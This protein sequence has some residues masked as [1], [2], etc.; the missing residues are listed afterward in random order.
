MRRKKQGLEPTGQVK[1]KAVADGFDN[2][3]DWLVYQETKEP[4]ATIAARKV[5]AAWA[6]QTA[7]PAEA[8]GKTATVKR[9]FSTESENQIDHASAKSSQ[10]GAMAMGSC[11]LPSATEVIAAKEANTATTK[12]R[13]SKGRKPQQKTCVDAALSALAAGKQI[14]PTTEPLSG[15]LVRSTSTVRSRMLSLAA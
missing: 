15:G 6:V 9:P 12:K 2:V 5:N 13:A 8:A 14:V 11:I 1:S 7:Q 4:A 10:T 3:H